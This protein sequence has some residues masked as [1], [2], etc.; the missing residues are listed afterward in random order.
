MSSSTTA[1]A[2]RFWIDRGGTFTDVVASDPQGRLHAMK[3]LSE[4][5][6]R[7]RDAAAEGIRRTLSAHADQPSAVAEIRMGTTVATNAL[8]ERTGEPTVLVTTR[9]F[10][11]ALHIGYQNRPDIFACNIVRPDPLP[12]EVIEADERIAADGAVVAPLDIEQLAADLSASFERGLRAVAIVFMHGYRHSDHEAIA[13]GIARDIGFTQVS[14]SHEVMPLMK[15]VSRGDTTVADAWLSPLIRRYLANFLADIESHAP[16]AVVRIM[17]S[18]GR[19]TSADTYRGRDSVLSGPAGG[20][21]GMA[22]TGAMAGI[23]RMIGFDMGG[24]S[25]DVSLY[26]GQYLRTQTSEIA[27]VRL[28]APMMDIHTVA[29]GGGS[30]LRYAAGRFLVGPQSAG[31]EHARES[32]ALNL[33]KANV[34]VRY[35]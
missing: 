29:A 31:A 12:T 32:P 6:A 3:L 10:A 19:L 18:S 11:D 25:T 8:L 33:A 17:Q 21:V 28:R 22:R 24:T 26:Q 23:D 15:L 13:A 35:R 20:I 9:G 30:V 5:P 14:T 4:D 34:R 1:A 27:G 16:D 7:Y 2:W